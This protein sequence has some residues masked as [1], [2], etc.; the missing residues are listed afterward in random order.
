MEAACDEFVLLVFFNQGV[1]YNTPIQ[2][3]RSR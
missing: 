1:M 3:P 2:T